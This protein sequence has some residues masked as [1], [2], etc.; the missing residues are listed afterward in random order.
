M[1]GFAN[2]LYGFKGPSNRGA[3]SSSHGCSDNTAVHSGE[4]TMHQ[5]EPV[6]GELPMLQ[7]T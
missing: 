1:L 3:D 6:P 2:I 7:R 4:D 5:R